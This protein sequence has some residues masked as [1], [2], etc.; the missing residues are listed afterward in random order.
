M[1]FMPHKKPLLLLG[2]SLLAACSSVPVEEQNEELRLLLGEIRAR[3]QVL[4]KRQKLLENRGRLLASLE[5]QQ[6]NVAVEADVEDVVSVG[7]DFL[8]APQATEGQCFL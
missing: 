1:L 7:G 3:E 8:T 4:D 2:V 6:E 5:L